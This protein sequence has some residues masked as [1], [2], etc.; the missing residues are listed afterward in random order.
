MMAFQFFVACICLSIS[1]IA[2]QQPEI[3]TVNADGSFSNTNVV[4]NLA[5]FMEAQAQSALAQAVAEAAH[6]SATNTERIVRD[7]IAEVQA[8]AKI[9]YSDLFVW[10][11][12]AFALSTNATCN[13]YNFELHKDVTTNISGVAHFAVDISYWFSE[14][15]GSYQPGVK[16]STNLDATNS[17]EMCI[18]DD[19]IGPF[20]DTTRS[21]ITVENAYRTRNWM[22]LY[23]SS[24]FFKAFTDSAAP[25]TGVTI[26]LVGGVKNGFTGRIVVPPTGKWLVVDVVG[27]VTTTIEARDT[28]P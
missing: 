19:A 3:L 25:G 18:Q 10:S 17:W 12:G 27:G 4:G 23:L 7:G 2:D 14:D 13:I 24:S 15:I 8:G 20:T 26:D 21:G 6:T 1:A 9:E 28:E 11:A 22:P 5:G 16:Y